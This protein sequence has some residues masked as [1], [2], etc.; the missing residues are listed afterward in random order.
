MAK[1]VFLSLI[2][3]STG[4]HADVET[5]ESIMLELLFQQFDQDGDGERALAIRRRRTPMRPHRSPKVAPLRVA[6]SAHPTTTPA[7][8]IGCLDLTEFLVG[9]SF[10]KNELNDIPPHEK[11]KFWFTLFDKDRN[12]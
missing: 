6:T 10:W 3:I 11:A 7:L 8:N 5:D 9:F 12:G 2:G 4:V 1:E